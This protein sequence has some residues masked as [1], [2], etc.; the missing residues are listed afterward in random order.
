M[1]RPAINVPI[2][3]VEMQSL[4]QVRGDGE[5]GDG[6]SAAVIEKQGVGWDVSSSQIVGGILDIGQGHRGH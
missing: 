5:G 2:G 3:G 4:G 1:S 6:S